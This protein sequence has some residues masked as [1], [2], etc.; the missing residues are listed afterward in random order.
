MQLIDRAEGQEATYTEN[1]GLQ[2]GFLLIWK[3]RAVYDFL[4]AHPHLLSC[5]DISEAIFSTLA[6][7]LHRGL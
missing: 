4:I 5:C 7:K 2:K 3:G 6:N 1:A